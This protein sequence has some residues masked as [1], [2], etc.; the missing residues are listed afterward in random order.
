MKFNRPTTKIAIP[1]TNCNSTTTNMGQIRKTR[2][3]RLFL[4]FRMSRGGGEQAEAESR[5]RAGGRASGDWTAGEQA[6]AESRRRGGGE[7]AESRRRRR[8]G[9]EPEAEAVFSGQPLFSRSPWRLAKWWPGRSGRFTQ[10]RRSHLRFTK[11][12]EGIII[13]DGFGNGMILDDIE[14]EIQK[15]IVQTKNS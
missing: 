6:E 11:K 1:P 12:I 7:Q 3:A 5:R 9:G 14:V 15:P 2:D 10:G 8:A 13:D 4:D